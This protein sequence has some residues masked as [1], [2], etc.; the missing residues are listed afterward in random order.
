MTWFQILIAAWSACAALCF[1]KAWTLLR[2][3]PVNS[4]DN[5]SSRHD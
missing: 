5:D 2:S 3:G 1:W 4:G